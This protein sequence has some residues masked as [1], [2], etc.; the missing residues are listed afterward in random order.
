MAL[1]LFTKD[2]TGASLVTS[3]C[4]VCGFVS[5]P[6][7]PICSRC[8]SEDAERL[9]GGRRGR[10]LSSAVVHHAPIG[11]EAP[12]VVGLVE[13]DEGPV[14]FCPIAGFPEGAHAVPRGASVELAIAPARLQGEPV[15]QFQRAAS[16]EDSR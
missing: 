12:Y 11:F 5:F 8:G 14:V 1:E 2:S 16:T 13:I 6:A 7:R 9:P 4:R 10:V 3:R 15:I